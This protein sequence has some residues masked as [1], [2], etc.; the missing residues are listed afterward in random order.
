MPA[1]AILPHFARIATEPS[2]RPFRADRLPTDRARFGMGFRKGVQPFI[3]RPFTTPSVY[4]LLTAVLD[5]FGR[6]DDVH[7]ALRG[8]FLKGS[9]RY[10]KAIVHDN[11][12]YQQL[13]E[14]EKKPL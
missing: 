7:G 8:E 14:P 4:E 10:A 13:S 9:I 12:Y 1:P 6:G 2:R 5:A 11:A 3:T